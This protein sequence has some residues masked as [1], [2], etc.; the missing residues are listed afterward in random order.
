M[1]HHSAG[2]NSVI[3]A[4][5]LTGR[6][7]WRH[8]PQ[9]V[10]LVLVGFL[11]N[12]LLLTV[13]IKIGSAN[14][15][16][17]LC[18]LSV[19]VLA[20]LIVY[21]VMFHALKPSLPVVGELAAS[22]VSAVNQRP[23]R[24]VDL[25]A[26]ALVPFFAY[27]AA[28]GFLSNTVR[29]YSLRYLDLGP[30]ATQGNLL[31]AMSAPGLIV[32][33]VVAWVLR[34]IAMRFQERTDR[35]V[36]KFLVTLCEAIWIF[37]GLFVLNSWKQRA[38][39][40]WHSRVIWHD[41]LRMREPATGAVSAGSSSPLK[42]AFGAV[43][44]VFFYALMPIIWLAMAALIYGREVGKADE[45]LASNARFANIA[46]RYEGMP[47]IL[48][49]AS[50]RLVQSYRTRFLPV[51][52]CVRLTLAAGVPLLVLLCVGY[53]ALNWLALWCWIG[54]THLIGPHSFPAWRIIG[55]ALGLL[56]VDPLQNNPSV[57][58]EPLRICLLAAVLETALAARGEESLTPAPVTAPASAPAQ[59]Q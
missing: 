17:G 13:A 56:L 57:L 33:V 49:L 6:L 1:C 22:T 10:L 32:V 20:K 8:W 45:I 54:A 27:Y 21:V 9:L 4:I 40:W 55:N 23:Y 42:D 11:A 36:W 2:M 28:W 14:H 15:L 43:T 44:D 59:A 31:D 5:A 30:F 50:E 58:V 46:Q 29:D 41:W 51:V 48:H 18:S 19:V 16:L 25:L 26:L 12:Q 3:S 53:R 47:A 52:N 37:I 35:A 39:D 7:W 38:T 34:K 24:F